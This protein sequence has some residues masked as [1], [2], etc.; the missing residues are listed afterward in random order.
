MV[1]SRSTHEEE[2]AFV[3]ANARDVHQELRFYIDVSRI[4]KVE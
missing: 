1:C 2:C 3:V 4:L